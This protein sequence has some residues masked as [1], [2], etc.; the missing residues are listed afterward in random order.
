MKHLYALLLLAAS[1]NYA[2]NTTK[3]AFLDQLLSKMTLE[4]KIGQL[5]LISPPGDI[6]TGAAVSA[7]A[8][9]YI[10][11]GKLGAVL[12]MTSI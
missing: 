4:E 11:D 12:N 10:I 2:Q 5:N 6:S 9:K 7:D 3:D 1:F 8:E